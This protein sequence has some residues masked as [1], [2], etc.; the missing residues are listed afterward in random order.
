MRSQQ[1]AHKRF[2]IFLAFSRRTEIVFP[3]HIRKSHARS[4][5]GQLLPQKLGIAATK[6]LNCFEH[7]AMFRILPYMV[8]KLAH[9]G[10]MLRVHTRANA[11]RAQSLAL[12]LKHSLCLA[13]LR[14][15]V[16]ASLSCSCEE[17]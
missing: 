7:N 2:E 13:L 16:V 9:R 17:G 14:H 10:G 4:L 8:R 3:T 6:P 11:Q 15:D 5:R 12:Q 1:L